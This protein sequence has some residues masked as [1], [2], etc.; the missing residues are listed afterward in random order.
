MSDVD[1]IAWQCDQDAYASIGQKCSAQSIMFMHENWKD[2]GLLEKMKANASKRS[3]EDFTNGPVITQTTKNILD[4]V[5]RLLRVPG[6]SLVFGGKPLE[7]HKIPEKHGAAEP[8][9]VYVPLEQTIKDEHFGVCST[10]ILPPSRW[11]L[12]IATIH[13]I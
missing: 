2:T 11:L 3:L 4:H 7:N 13:L 8:T 1:Y 6:A 9:A 10:E 5:D 12:G